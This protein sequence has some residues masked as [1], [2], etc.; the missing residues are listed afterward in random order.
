M[1]VFRELTIR[2]EPDQ[3]AAAIEAIMTS[4]SEGWSRSA[5]FEQLQPHRPDGDWVSYVFKREPSGE[6]P[7]VILSLNTHGND[8][9]VA[10]IVSLGGRDLS[11]AEYNAVIEEFYRRFVRPAVAGTGAVAELTAGV[12]DLERWMSPEVAAKLR[13]FNL[14]ANKHSGSRHPAA[15]K[16]WYDF[17]AAAHRE[18]T[19]FDASTLGEWL[20]EDGGWNEEWAD[21]LAGEYGFARGL[22][23]YADQRTAVG[24]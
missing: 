11:R 4:V 14:A 16:L 21:D 12:A 2:G 20:R 18:G 17:L 1:Q 24:A 6:E 22:L 5:E 9:R 13:R 10:N 8:Y 3:L 7:A 23:T 19:K 15:R